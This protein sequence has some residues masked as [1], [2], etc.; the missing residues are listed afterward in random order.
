M[1]YAYSAFA[2]IW[3]DS[4]RFAHIRCFTLPKSAPPGRANPPSATS[5]GTISSQCT[6]MMCIPGC[7]GLLQ[8]LDQLQ[9]DGHARLLLRFLVV[10]CRIHA[11]RESPAARPRQAPSPP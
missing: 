7:R 9:R 6:A 5:R 1:H 8:L 4:S 2:F 11:L 3:G 10:P